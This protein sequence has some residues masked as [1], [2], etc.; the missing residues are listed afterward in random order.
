[1]EDFLMH[2]L[3]WLI[4]GLARGEAFA[5]MVLADMAIILGG[6]IVYDSWVSKGRKRLR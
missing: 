1:V 6:A 2:S 4:D 3:V 5:W